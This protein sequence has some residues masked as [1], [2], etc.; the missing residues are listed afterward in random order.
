MHYLILKRNENILRT[1]EDAGNPQNPSLALKLD[2]LTGI[3]EQLWHGGGGTIHFFLLTL[4]NF[5][6]IR[7][8]CAPPAPYSAVPVL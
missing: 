5:R 4:Y 1:F 8:W 2:V 3:A 6:N 7:G